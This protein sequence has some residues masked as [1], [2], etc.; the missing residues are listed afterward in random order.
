[1]NQDREKQQAPQEHATGGSMLDLNNSNQSMP[2]TIR[3]AGLQGSGLNSTLHRSTK[4]RTQTSSTQRQLAAKN[5]KNV[6]GNKS[7]QNTNLHSSNFNSNS[8]INQKHIQSL[9]EKGIGLQ[10]HHNSQENNTAML[11]NIENRGSHSEKTNNSQVDHQEYFLCKALH[12]GLLY[13]PPDSPLVQHLTQN[14]I[15][16]YLQPRLQKRED[17]VQ[18]F[19]Q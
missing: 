13:L 19:M 5:Q 8:S 10:V 15:K 7:V 11:S 9:Q 3:S 2:S 1:M 4:D 18:K 14:Y 12:F 17:L 6:D 16:N